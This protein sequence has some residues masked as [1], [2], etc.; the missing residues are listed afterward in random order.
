MDVLIILHHACLTKLLQET[1]VMSNDDELEVRMSSTFVDNALLTSNI[2][3]RLRMYSGF[4]SLDETC[5]QSVNILS[6][7]C[8]GRLV[9][10]KNATV[11][12]K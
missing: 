8:V 6:I 10:C 7:Q 9:Q 5:S 3:S 2:V 1:F 4:G 12:T 11:L